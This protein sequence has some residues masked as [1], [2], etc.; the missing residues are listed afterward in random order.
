MSIFYIET[1]ALVK[2]YHAENGTDVINAIFSEKAEADI[3]VTSQFITLEME[4]VAARGLKGGVL[5]RRAYGIMLRSFVEDLGNM[6]VL[7]LSPSLVTE[8]AQATRRYAMRAADA[9]HFASALRTKQ[10]AA[11]QIVFVGSDEELVR[12]GQ[13]EG[14]TVLNPETDDAM[15]R[16]KGLR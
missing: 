8:A 2:R 6:I 4:A 3:F 1:S 10:A 9:I 15:D 11:M 5:N 13:E 7:P 12:A 16:F 14:F